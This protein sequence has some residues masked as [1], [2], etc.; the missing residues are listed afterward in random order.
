MYN[1][2]YMSYLASQI[3]PFQTDKTKLCNNEV[4]AENFP[5]NVCVC[6]KGISL[7]TSV[8]VHETPL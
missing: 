2:L 1:I 6:F 8:R 4:F 3:P 5:S 7:D